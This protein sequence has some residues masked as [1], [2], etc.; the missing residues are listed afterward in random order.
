MPRHEPEIEIA[1]LKAYYRRRN[2]C[3]A[4]DTNL[5]GYWQTCIDRLEGDE[6]VYTDGVRR[7]ETPGA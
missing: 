7:D 2:A 6:I 4:D 1:N 5:I 3:A